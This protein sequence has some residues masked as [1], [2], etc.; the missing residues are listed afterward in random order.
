MNYQFKD[1]VLTL[2][3]KGEINS[4]NAGDIEKEVEPI[5]KKEPFSSLV[6]DFT[7]LTYISSA[8]LRIVLKMKQRCANT[9][10]VGCSLTVYD[11]LEMTGFTN[12]MTV[13]KALKSISVEGAEVVG[14]GYFSTVYRID[15][16]TIVKVFNRVS[17]PE[18]VERELS[19]AKEAFILGI[20]TAIS[21]D[22]VKVGE[23]LGVRFEML[24]C[25][26]LRNVFRD[27]PNRYDEFLEK[28][29][30]LLHTIN[31]T[32]PTS[33][34]LSSIKSDYKRKLEVVKAA[35]TDEEYRKLSAMID[36]IPDA[37]TFVHGDCHVKNIMVQ[38]D[39]LLL[40]DMDT[41]SVG[42]PIFEY[43]AIYAAYIGFEENEPGN[44][45]VFFGLEPDFTRKLA[46]DLI[47]KAYGR[48]DQETLD[49][50]ALLC[51]LHM[52]WW[53]TANEPENTRNFEFRINNVKKRLAILDNL[54]IK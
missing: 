21:Y 35:F 10:V 33:K 8:G 22:I 37:L 52:A 11:I 23:K 36:G 7:N 34:S 53:T 12:I 17:D 14:S 38:N 16:D 30:N 15:K 1:N 20:P 50:I 9:S 18:Q 5:L 54:I 26:S 40:I 3:F 45:R 43:A 48:D 4:V 31:S 24:D 47:R 51:F 42:D 41:L 49:K 6:L 19:R 29:A 32:E 44:S 27:N 25:D 46:H 13:S 28:Y 39:E 2:F